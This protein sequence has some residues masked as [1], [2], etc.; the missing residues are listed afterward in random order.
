MIKT[1]TIFLLLFIGSFSHAQSGALV[2]GL[3]TNKVSIGGG[4]PT[5]Y[6]VSDGT[7]FKL[8]FIGLIDYTA[9]V[10]FRSGAIFTQRKFSLNLNGTKAYDLEIDYLD[11]PLSALYKFNEYAGVFGGAVM[12][13]QVA[14]SCKGA[15]TSCTM[16]DVKS[17]IYGLEVGGHFVFVP[18]FGLEVSYLLGMSDVQGDANTMFK[19]ASGVSATF[20]YLF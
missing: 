7:G 18:N 3:Q 15:S 17:L 4:N 11:I 12:S 9:D 1:I 2:A 10:S 5:A 8:G 14:S 20:M 19:N 16:S 13:V 6:T